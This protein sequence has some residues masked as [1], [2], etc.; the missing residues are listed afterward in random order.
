VFGRGAW[1]QIMAGNLFAAIAMGYY[2]LRTHRELREEFRHS[3][4]WET[5]PETW[6]V[7]T[8]PADA[9]KST[10]VT[11]PGAPRI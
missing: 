3:L 9:T 7:S 1:I 10:V 4:D 5:R 8:P 6:G 2:F 11:G